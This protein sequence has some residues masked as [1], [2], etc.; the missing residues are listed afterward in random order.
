MTSMSTQTPASGSRL[1]TGTALPKAGRTGSGAAPLKNDN[2]RLFQTM[3][4]WVGAS[5]LPLGLA[6]RAG[7]RRRRAA[8]DGGRREH[9]APP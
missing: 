8:R 6:Q 9:H 2:S 4:F 1:G 5:L 7:R 3:L